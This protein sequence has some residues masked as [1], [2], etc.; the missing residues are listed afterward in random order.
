MSIDAWRHVGLQVAAARGICCHVD[1]CLGGFV[2]PFAR[3]L[4]RNV[5]A[6]DFA[7][8]LADPCLLMAV[9]VALL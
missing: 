6:F 1:A 2:L 9:S 7:V 5:P 8:R 4:G 3:K